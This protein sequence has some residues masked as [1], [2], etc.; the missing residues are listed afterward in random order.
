M[1]I[2]FITE[3]EVSYMGFL[4]CVIAVSIIAAIVAAVVA[5]STGALIGAQEIDDEE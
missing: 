5:A 4:V 3:T 1:Q 2:L